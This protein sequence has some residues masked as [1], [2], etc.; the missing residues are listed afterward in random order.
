M[1]FFSLLAIFLIAVVSYGQD[2]KGYYITNSDTRID[3]YFKPTDFAK[4]DKIQIRQ[5]ETGEYQ[6]LPFLTAKEYGIS[7]QFKFIKRTVKVDKSRSD[8]QRYYSTFKEAEL[9][10]TELFLNVLV[11]GDASLYS[12]YFNEEKKYFYSIDSKKIKITQLVHKMYL[13]GNEV[14]ENKEYQQTLYNEVNCGDSSVNFGT[15]SYKESSLK[16]V[17]EAYNSCKSSQYKVYDNKGSLKIEL[18]VSGYAGPTM[19]MLATKTQGGSGNDSS[20]GFNLGA[21]AVIVMPAGNLGGFFRLEYAMA[22]ELETITPFANTNRLVE[23]SVLNASFFSAVLGPRYF[24]SENKNKKGFFIDAGFGMSFAFGDLTKNQLATNAQ[25]EYY[26]ASTQ[27]YNLAHNFYLTAGFGYALSENM[28]LEVRYDTPREVVDYN[29]NY[30]F[31]KLGLN[32][33]YTF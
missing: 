7:D 17:F 31:S 20:I 32:F 4:T 26:T 6:S 3:V 21:E 18:L 22:T 27:T 8:S 25:G 5:N 14:K 10:K 24:L 13:Y 1:R 9:E 23:Q 33:K 15:L 30:K 2:I 19:N 16:K 29:S 12:G 11:E 28:G